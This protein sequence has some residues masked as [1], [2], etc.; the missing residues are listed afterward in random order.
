VKVAVVDATGKVVATDTIY[1]HVPRNKWDE[2]IATLARLSAAHR[3]DLI[4]I[5]NGTAS[6]ET[7]KL[8][9]DLIKRHPELKLTKAVVSEA[10]ASVYSAS[11]YASAELPELDVS[12]R[13]AVS[14][15]RRLQDPLAELVK[16]DP[17]SIG[18]GQYQHDV[19]QPALKRSLDAV[20]E[21]CVNYV[22]VDLN[23]ASP[24]LLRYVS[25]LNQLT[26]RRLYD[27]RQQNGP[28]KSRE[29]LK[30]VPGFGEATF[31]QAA[32]FLRLTDSE[33]PLDGTWIH[34]ESYGVAQGVLERLGYSPTVL[35]D[36]ET[37]AALAQKTA[38]V[39]VGTLAAE[40]NAG[41]LLLAD[42]IAQLTRPGRD[43]REDLPEPIFKRGIL[44]LDDLATG[45]ELTGCVLNVVDFGAFVD[46]GLHDS[47]LVHISHL[48]NKFIRDP[49]DV[50]A[51]GDIVKVWVLAIDKN[52]RR[53][54]LT[55]V[56]PGT[57]RPAPS[58]PAQRPE[59]RREDRRPRPPARPPRPAV[60]GNQQQGARPQGGRRPPVGG[61]GRPVAPA[62]KFVRPPKPA[63]PPKPLSK[64]MKEGRAPLRTFGDLKQFVDLQEKKSDPPPA[65]A[66]PP[67]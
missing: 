46:I 49:H 13:G 53:V 32:G 39:Q 40:L 20:V 29:Q 35:K 30:E 17:K 34:P 14:I 55:M 19:N 11:A 37:T 12:L 56:Q 52:R 67:Q 54:S 43:P 4:A 45:M 42:I 24:A 25:G 60:V 31:V 9:A 51:V 8:A 6:R 58:P 26:A 44:K 66:A 2:S 16:I 23:T 21:S 61:G 57:E 33:N 38:E 18:V 62:K 28:F 36:K 47:G 48:A 65:P 63:A 1:P 15:A 10:G 64:A 3:V 59:G 27:Y 22:G 50:V 7:D 41:G 5:G